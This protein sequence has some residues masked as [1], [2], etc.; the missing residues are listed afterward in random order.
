M[1]RGIPKPK[2][3]E[4]I[5]ETTRLTYKT[6]EGLIESS[7]VLLGSEICIVQI[8][9][10]NKVYRILDLKTKKFCFM[11]GSGRDV[12][13]LKKKARKRLLECKASIYQEIRGNK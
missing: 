12:E 10:T 7:P 11:L 3:K 1:K 9:K 5:R 6:T 8:D 2:T 4:Y 13:D